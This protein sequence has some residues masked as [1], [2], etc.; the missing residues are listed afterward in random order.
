[1]GNPMSVTPICARTDPSMNST[2]ECTMLCGWTI[3]SICRGSKSKNQLASMISNP[4]FISVAESMVIFFPMTHV[5]CRR[6]SSGVILLK[7]SRGRL[8]NGPPEEVRKPLFASV[9]V[10]RQT[11]EDRRGLTIH[12]KKPDAMGL[13]LGHHQF[14]RHDHDLFGR[15]REILPGLDRCKA[16]KQAGSADHGGEDDIGLGHSGDAQQPFD[17]PP[18]LDRPIRDPILQRLGG[19]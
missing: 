17:S 7:L 14:P 9:I 5:G 18:D 3:T 15:E 12:R 2:I 10:P 11:L 19:R 13:D 4:L 8:R 1:M 16:W 6:A